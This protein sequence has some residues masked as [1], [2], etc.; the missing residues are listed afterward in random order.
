MS[1]YL[2][3]RSACHFSEVVS[4]TR[5]APMADYTGRKRF[6]RANSGQYSARG[7][8]TLHIVRGDSPRAL[9]N[10]DQNGPVSPSIFERRVKALAPVS[11][12]EPL[13]SALVCSRLIGLA[14]DEEWLHVLVLQDLYGRPLGSVALRDRKERVLRV[15]HHRARGRSC[16]SSGTWT[17]W[18]SAAEA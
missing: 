16:G 11:G 15:R 8:G 9:I 17:A 10:H 1:I 2:G 3:C 5:H 7:S 6:L 13:R 4:P 18:P 12:V 14:L